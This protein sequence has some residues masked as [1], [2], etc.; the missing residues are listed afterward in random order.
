VEF[1]GTT[2]KV[3]L[4]TS[5]IAALTHWYQVRCLLPM[6]IFIKQGQ[7]LTGRVL[8]EANRR[9]S[10]DVTI[11][12]QI[13]GTLI[14][15]KNTLDLKN[16]YFRYT[17]APVQQPAGTNSQSPS[18]QYWSQFDVNNVRNSMFYLKNICKIFI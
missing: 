3:W 14:S 1:C 8:L 2:Q 15:S 9:Q 7:I 12:V 13:Q 17:G 5:P 16:P 18:E 6:P 4:S 10:Y 11:D